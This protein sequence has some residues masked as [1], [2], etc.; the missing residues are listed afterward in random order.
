MPAMLNAQAVL[1]SFVPVSRFNKGE[2]SQ[3]ISEV[4]N[5]GIKFVVQN[6]AP[7]CVILSLKSYQ[8]ILEDLEDAEL[9]AIAF[10]REAKKSRTIP[11][12]KIL[13]ENGI[14]QSDLD[15]VSDSEIEIE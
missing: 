9:A 10:E 12:E 5:D 4:K 13:A 3:I 11:F 2:A 14:S 8:K 6:N 15:A 1:N 7:E